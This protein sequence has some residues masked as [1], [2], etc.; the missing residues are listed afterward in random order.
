MK[1]AF[2]RSP[3]SRTAPL[4][5]ALA[6]LGCTEKP[7]PPAVD[8]YGHQ[9]LAVLPF[10]NTSADPTLATAIVAELMAGLEVLKPAPLAGPDRTAPL[11]PEPVLIPGAGTLATLAAAT[12]SDLVITGEVAGYRET[13]KAGEPKRIKASYRAGSWKWGC[14]DDAVVTFLVTVRLAEVA[15]GRQTWIRTVSA[16]GKSSRWT[17]L[18]YDGDEAKPPPDGWEAVRSK[19]GIPTLPLASTVTGSAAPRPAEGGAPPQFAADTNL[20]HARSE[21]IAQVAR[22]VLNDFTGRGGWAPAAAPTRP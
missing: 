10:R 5:I 13:I 9:G 7:K 6:I 4:V 21:A 17:D 11:V 3:I 19:S 12:G 16:E 2:G 8:M 20:A 1:H 15:T 22:A 18:A 14:A